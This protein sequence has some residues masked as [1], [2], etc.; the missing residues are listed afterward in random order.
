[1]SSVQQ[2]KSYP[3]KKFAKGALLCPQCQLRLE[4]PVV[5]CP[6]C[7]FTGEQTLQ[8]FPGGAPEMVRFI[9]ADQHWDDKSRRRIEKKLEQMARLFP[10]IHWCLLTINLPPQ[11][12]LRL[13]NFW[14]FNVS[15]LSPQ[16]DADER[17]WTVLLTFDYQNRRLAIT[18]GY[19]VEPFL[20]DDEWERLLM[21]LGERVLVE[22]PLTGYLSF[23]AAMR[24]LLIKSSS[25]LAEILNHEERGGM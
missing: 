17:I 14:F 25:R 19:A 4:E 6:S 9:D 10:Q 7:Q 2:S 11:A 3:A 20:A 24:T 21:T 8:M 16:S 5:S 1:M 13:F 22:K 12:D 23:F 18:P 15:P